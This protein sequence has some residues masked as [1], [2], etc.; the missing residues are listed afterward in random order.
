[1]RNTKLCPPI[2]RTKEYETLITLFS[3]IFFLRFFHHCHPDFFCAHC[4]WGGE[5][6][7]SQG[8]VWTTAPLQKFLRAPITYTRP[9]SSPIYPLDTTHCAQLYQGGWWQSNCHRGMLTGP[10]CASAD[11]VTSSLGLMWNEYKGPATCLK[12]AIMAF[13]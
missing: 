13:Q 12:T 1:M 5:F 2:A 7:P 4:I 10:Y 6:I 11:A 9:S 8:F 3:R